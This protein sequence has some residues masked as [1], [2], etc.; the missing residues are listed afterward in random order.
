MKS[1]IPAAIAMLRAWLLNFKT[2]LPVQGLLVGQTSTQITATVAIAQE[3]IALVDTLTAAKA[4]QKSA[5]TALHTWKK[6]GGTGLAVLRDNIDDMKGDPGYTKAIGDILGT[7]SIEEPF[8]AIDYK[9]VGKAIPQPGY[10][11]I[12]FEKLGVDLMSIDYRVKGTSGWVHLGNVQNSGFHHA[13]TMPVVTPPVSPAP[14]SVDLQYQL[15]GILHDVLIG[16]PSDPF[17]A[18]LM[19]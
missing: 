12:N 8:D 10:N 14:T 5:V 1:F 18:T 9:P 6:P 16:H 4:A 19:Y 13:Y 7:V 3:G 17:G 15:T 11:L 2:V